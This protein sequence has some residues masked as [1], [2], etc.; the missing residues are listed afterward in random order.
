MSGVTVI[1]KCGRWGS[2]CALGEK[3]YRLLIYHSRI[4]S[5]RTFSSSVLMSSTDFISMR[6]VHRYSATWNSY[7]YASLPVTKHTWLAGS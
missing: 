5:T 4:D 3:P 1:F 7:C 6:T 2:D